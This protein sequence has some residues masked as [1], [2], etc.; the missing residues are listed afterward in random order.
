MAQEHKDSEFQNNISSIR[1][2]DKS[3][4]NYYVTRKAF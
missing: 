3:K 2:L 4:A 1:N